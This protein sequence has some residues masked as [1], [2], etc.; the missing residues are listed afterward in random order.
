METEGH[1]KPGLDAE[2]GGEKSITL[3]QDSEAEGKGTNGY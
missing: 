2:D 3:S 1:E